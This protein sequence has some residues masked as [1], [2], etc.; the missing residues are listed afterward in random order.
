MN[1]AAESADNPLW[2][3]ISGLR[4]RLKPGVQFARHVYRGQP[5]YVLRDETST[6]NYRFNEAAQRFLG[7]LN[8]SRTVS[9]AL[10]LVHE[11][12]PEQA[13]GQDEVVHGGNVHQEGYPAAR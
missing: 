6:R 5:W 12:M 2:Q 1:V 9:R 11:Q 4:P 13:P 3:Q 10:E 8:G 7:L